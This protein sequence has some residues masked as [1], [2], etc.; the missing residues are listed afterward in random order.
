[1]IFAV[2][3]VLATVGHWSFAKWWIDNDMGK[4]EGKYYRGVVGPDTSEL[5]FWSACVCQLYLSAASL[6]QL[7][8]RQHSGGVNWSMW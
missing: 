5:G 8:V 4:R 6:A 2:M 3:A 7:L 1:M